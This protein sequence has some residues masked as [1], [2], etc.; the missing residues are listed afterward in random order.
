MIC[1]KCGVRTSDE[2]SFYEHRGTEIFGVQFR[3]PLL[4]SLKRKKNIGLKERIIIVYTVALNFRR[5]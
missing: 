5:Q 4:S 3:K 1:S 2:S